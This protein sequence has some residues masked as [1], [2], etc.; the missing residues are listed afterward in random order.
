MN[1]IRY[2]RQTAAE[3]SSCT[4][5]LLA[6]VTAMCIGACSG[7]KEEQGEELLR[8]VANGQ[9]DR[10][11]ALLEKSDVD[12]N[13]LVG[14]E[15]MHALFVASGSGNARIVRMLLENGA[16][17]DLKTG[18]GFSALGISSTYGHTEIIEI[19]L[20]HGADVNRESRT[21][22]GPGEPPC[23]TR[24]AD[25]HEDTVRLLL[26]RGGQYLHHQ[27][28]PAPHRPGSDAW[29]QGCT[30]ELSGGDGEGI[31]DGGGSS[32]IPHART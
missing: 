28:E 27:Q 17:P 6:V 7:S 21:G 1:A 5:A 13:T 19:L 18:Q 2:L 12:P 15:G 23:I 16:E 9:S 11:Q 10:V 32:S 29:R 26:R 30:A 8:A 25:G 4:L 31:P 24:A 3:N 22:R 14:P 20:D